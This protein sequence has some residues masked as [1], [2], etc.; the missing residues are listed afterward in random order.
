MGS[1]INVAFATEEIIRIKAEQRDNAAFMASLLHLMGEHYAD[2]PTLKKETV[3]SH[4]EC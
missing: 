2:V 4:R 1:T 3:K